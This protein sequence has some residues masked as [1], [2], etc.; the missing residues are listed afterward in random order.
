MVS[1]KCHQG[2]SKERGKEEDLVSDILG[3]PST[4]NR[5]GTSLLERSQLGLRD[6][7]T[8]GH[9]LGST[10]ENQRLSSKPK[11]VLKVLELQASSRLPP[12]HLD[13]RSLF[14]EESIC[15]IAMVG[16]NFRTIWALL[17]GRTL[18]LGGGPTCTEIYFLV[19]STLSWHPCDF[20][21]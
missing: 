19:L 15:H 13:G 12:L 5:D 21:R 18:G 20:L 14:G 9:C 2:L 11:C 1:L 3:L 8:F 7:V 6:F 16:W 17:R 4:T 10:S